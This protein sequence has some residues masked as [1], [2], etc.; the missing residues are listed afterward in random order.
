MDVP[1]FKTYVG[2][3][4]KM[5]AERSQPPKPAICRR[6]YVLFGRFFCWKKFVSKAFNYLIQR[7]MVELQKKIDHYHHNYA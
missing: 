5:L 4:K 3:V 6:N 2:T 7:E 1:L